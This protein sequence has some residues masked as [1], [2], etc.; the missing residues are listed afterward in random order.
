MA[1]SPV[2]LLAW[3]YEKLHDW[4]DD[5]PWTDD[6]VLTWI[7][8][9]WFSTAGPAASARIYYE[10]THGDPQYLKA[11]PLGHIPHVKLGLCFAPKE[12]GNVP[13]SWAKVMGPIA[14]QSEKNK[15]GHF[16]AW[17]QPHEIVSD[18]RNMFGEGGGCYKIL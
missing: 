4:T 9:Y 3:I 13:R 5:Y 1:D 10:A 11:R 6:E 14:F 7:S 15:G 17:E 18:L 16:L 8:I 12:L 2:A